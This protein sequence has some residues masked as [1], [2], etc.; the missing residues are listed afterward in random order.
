LDAPSGELSGQ[1][2]LNLGTGSRQPRQRKKKLYQLPPQDDLEIE[3]KRLRSLKE[4]NYRDKK[5]KEK[6]NLEHSLINI[7]MEIANLRQKVVWGH[8]RVASFEH[9]L[10]HA[11]TLPKQL[12]Q[13]GTWAEQQ[14]SYNGTYQDTGEERHG[15]SKAGFPAWNDICNMVQ[16]KK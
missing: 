7:N 1:L 15:Y 5:E 16:S 11:R 2:S 8:E 9:Q 14:L 13:A 12:T 4:F 6:K 10:V 3:M